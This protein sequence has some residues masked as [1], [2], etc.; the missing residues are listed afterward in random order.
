MYTPKDA[1]LPG[2]PSLSYSFPPLSLPSS[3]RV[4]HAHLPS[5]HP[6]QHPFSLGH[7]VSTGLSIS[8]PI[9]AIQGH[10]LLTR[11]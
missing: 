8:S 1:S 4:L 2:S 10:P 5:P 9:E 6:H 3:E 11:A 7:Q